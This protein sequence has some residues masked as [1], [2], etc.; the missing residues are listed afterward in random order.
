M[1]DEKIVLEKFSS[2][3]VGLFESINEKNKNKNKM[4]RTDAYKL[5]K[6]FYVDQEDD[7]WYV[8]GTES[9][10]AYSNHLDGKEAEKAAVK[11]SKKK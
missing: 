1:K 11:L 2:L 8:F 4:N 6:E 3:F 9:G 5:D 7:V 10:F